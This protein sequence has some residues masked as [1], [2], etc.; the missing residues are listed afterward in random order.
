MPT[1]YHLIP[2]LSKDSDFRKPENRSALNPSCFVKMGLFFK[3]HFC[4]LQLEVK[5]AYD[6]RPPPPVAKRWLGFRK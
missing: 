6:C 5:S 4:D 1:A 3:T 2:Q